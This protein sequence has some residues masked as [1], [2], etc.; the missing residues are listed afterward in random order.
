MLGDETNGKYMRTGIVTVVDGIENVDWADLSKR[1][2]TCR[3][4]YFVT[5]RIERCAP[6][7]YDGS[8]KCVHCGAGRQSASANTVKFTDAKGIEQYEERCEFVTSG[9]TVWNDSGSTMGWYAVKSG[10]VNISSRIKVNGNVNLVLCDG[11][12]LNAKEGISV[13]DGSRLTIWG[14]FG[15]YTVPTMTSV[16][17]FGTGKLNATTSDSG[18]YRQAAAIG[19]ENGADSGV[20]VINGGVITAEG[21]WGAGIGR[22]NVAQPVHST[23][24]SVTIN[25]GYVNAS[26]SSGSAGIGSGAYADSCPVTITG[27][28]VSAI[29]CVY[30]STGQATSGIGTGRPRTNGSDPL[31]CGKVTITGGTVIAKAG[32]ADK[33]AM[34]IG[35]NSADFSG[36]DYLTIGE[37]MA[38]YCPINSAA[39]Q[40]RAS[41]WYALALINSEIKIAPCPH[42]YEN[43]YCIYCGAGLKPGDVNLDGKVTPLDAMILARYLA[44][45]KGYTVDTYAADVDKDNTVTVKDAMILARH[46]AGWNGYGTLPYKEN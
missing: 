29:G 9:L 7:K 33:S 27:G 25:G 37:E 31:K 26:G 38:V 40:Q 4:E 30:E 12:T 3:K 2:S 17:T 32:S 41:Y 43:G 14:Q 5:I 6:H 1:E 28:V 15:V 24:G 22:G 39:P 34:A 46:L 11:A 8:G 23:A 16:N 45:W 21:K 42:S 19:G 35:V 44:G 18:S 36:G 20:I 13:P 10:E